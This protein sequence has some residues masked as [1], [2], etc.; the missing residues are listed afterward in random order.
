MTRRFG[1][2]LHAYVLMDNRYHLL[3]ELTE[4][5]LSRSVQWLNREKLKEQVVLGG[6][7]FLERV[8]RQTGQGGLA[9]RA[10]AS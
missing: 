4:A 10:S 2:Q 6:E 9:W 3:L 1:V 8:R 7:K 5:N